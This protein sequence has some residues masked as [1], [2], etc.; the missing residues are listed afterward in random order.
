MKKHTAILTVLLMLIAPSV[1]AAS[2]AMVAGASGYVE[3]GGDVTAPTLSSITIGTNGTSWTFAYSENVTGSPTSDLCG[4]YTAAMTTAGAITLTYASGDGTN[5][6]VCSGSPTVNSGDTV[7][8]GGVDYTQ[9]GNGIEDAAGNDLASLTDKAVTNNSTQSAAYCTQRV[10]DSFTA[11]DTT[12]MAARGWYEY[13]ADWDIYTNRLRWIN[14]TNYANSRL[15]N[16]TAMTTA[17]QYVKVTYPSSVNIDAGAESGVIFRATSSSSLT[18]HYLIGITDDG[19]ITSYDGSDN[20]ID[21]EGSTT[22][23]SIDGVGVTLC[24]MVKG[25]GAS[26]VFSLWRNCTNNTPYSGGTACSVNTKPCWDNAAD[27]PDYQLTGTPTN[28]SNTALYVGLHA[29][30]NTDSS[31]VVWYFTNFFA[32]DCSD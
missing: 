15:I 18:D 23:T 26:T 2:A 4:A 19:T 11:S 29:Y 14:T 8:N 30:E 31:N 3:A 24:S 32:G 17:T 10:T 12:D 5:S 27:A 25:T 6:V 9:P 21:T 7:A 20:T 16:T 1:W 22:F 28:V 13:S